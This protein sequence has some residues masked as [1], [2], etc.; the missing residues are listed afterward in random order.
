MR[1]ERAREG[2]ASDRPV[3]TRVPRIMECSRT[4]VG[5]AITVEARCTGLVLYGRIH[6]F[7]AYM[8]LLTRDNMNREREQEDGRLQERVHRIFTG[9][10]L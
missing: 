4:L 6:F 1:L 8:D 9:F 2:S 7:F 10:F 3:G 5:G